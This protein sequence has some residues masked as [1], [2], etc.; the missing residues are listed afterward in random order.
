MVSLSFDI[1]RLT[2][3][4]S[5]VAPSIQNNNVKCCHELHTQKNDLYH[6]AM[7]MKIITQPN[8]QHHTHSYHAGKTR[9]SR[10]QIRRRRR[11]NPLHLPLQTLH[12]RRNPPRQGHRKQNLARTR[13]RRGT[14]PPPPRAPTHSIPN[15]AGKDDEG[16]CQSCS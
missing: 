9:R 7:D 8:T 1:N 6:C 15:A 2:N 5:F 4:V 14:H 3:Y 13:H 10:S 11:G 16:H 12:L